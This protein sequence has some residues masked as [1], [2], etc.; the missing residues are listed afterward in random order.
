PIPIAVTRR[1]NIQYKDWDGSGGLENITDLGLDY[2]LSTEWKAENLAPSLEVTGAYGGINPNTGGESFA[3]NTNLT[4]EQFD[5]LSA[6][7]GGELA[8]V[9]LQG[10][11]PLFQPGPDGETSGIYDVMEGVTVTFDAEDRNPDFYSYM[12]VNGDGN[13]DLV[14]YGVKQDNDGLSDGDRRYEIT[15]MGP[16]LQPL[17]L[18][19]IRHTD[20]NHAARVAQLSPYL[21]QWGAARPELGQHG[22]DPISLYNLATES[23]D[24][25][26]I[27]ELYQIDLGFAVDLDLMQG[28]LASEEVL[29]DAAWEGLEF[30]TQPGTTNRRDALVADL[31][32]FDIAGY[33][34]A[35]P[36]LRGEIAESLGLPE[37]LIGGTHLAHHYMVSGNAEGRSIDPAGIYLDVGT[38]PVR[39]QSRSAGNELWAGEELRAGEALFSENGQ[40]AAE[41]TLGGDLVIRDLTQDG[42]PE[43]WDTNNGGE[44]TDHGGIVMQADGNLVVYDNDGAEF[45]HIDAGFS[46]GTHNETTHGAF[47]LRLENDGRL[48][49]RDRTDNSVLWVAGQGQDEHGNDIDN[50]GHGFFVRAAPT[51]TDLPEPTESA[52]AN[53]NAILFTEE[54]ALTYLASDPALI[55]QWQTA[56]GDPVLWARNHFITT[57]QGGEVVLNSNLV[58]L[59]LAAPGNDDLVMAFRDDP[60]GALRHYVTTGV[61]EVSAEGAPRNLA[62]TE[63]DTPNAAYLHADD[64]L[65]SDLGALEYLAA[66][67]GLAAD[68]MASDQDP[69]TAA[70]NHFRDIGWHPG[71]GMNFDFDV[72]SY[73]SA[74]GNG[75]LM[76]AFANDPIGAVN[77]YLYTG[78]SEF[79]EGTR[80]DLDLS[81]GETANTAALYYEPIMET[82]AG[83]LAYLASNPGLAADVM[84]SD[85]DPI[86]AARN[87]FTS[88][89]WQES[90][91][92]L[93]DFSPA[94][95]ISAPGNDDLVIAFADDPEGA[96]LHFLETGR[97]EIADGTRPY[98]Q[99][100]GGVEEN[101][102]YA[103]Y[104][105][106]METEEGAYTYL[107]SNPG[108]ID[109]ANENG[110][111]DLVTFARDHFTTSGWSDGF[112]MDF[113]A[114]SYLSAP[115]NADLARAFG[116]DTAA[117]V[118]HFVTTGY[119]EVGSETSNRVV[120]RD[121]ND[122]P[123]DAYLF[124]DL[125]METDEG[126][127][128]YL[129]AN[130]GLH[131]D[132]VASGEDPVT[133]A[134]NHF[135]AVGWQPNYGM[136]F[137]PPPST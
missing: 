123:S 119:G 3:H 118:E 17:G 57:G 70:R 108:L 77:H 112:S 25:A 54:G 37:E 94:S 28:V 131:D 13:P 6:E 99:R 43:I 42:H 63:E 107:A 86:T 44:N 97:N 126:A 11:N 104:D 109:Y 85:A 29:D 128:A 33:A 23:G 52:N 110:I 89:G 125:I 14:R 27:E 50:N 12:D 10:D 121:P 82:D 129:D 111:E 19:T 55:E 84:A 60:V 46:S 34:D 120:S 135:A 58:D 132:V 53:R 56:G 127:L 90:H 32:L 75:D 71:H 15:L 91:G 41:F 117:G 98:G 30:E 65:E 21:M 116:R 101:P 66:N 95:Y 81:E 87:H 1:Q 45:H 100:E 103:A 76:I 122:L 74:P 51:V 26:G 130:P 137:A 134:R 124:R 64:I 105:E 114:D 61:G 47:V 88:V 79:A 80:A 36:T 38:T 69:V 20:L 35:N 62:L 48:V 136:N 5:R 68:I 102:T 8:P 22:N 4:P 72:E 9:T 24:L 49:I 115:E 113:D 96:T 67:P 40:F 2:E 18:P 106:I 83:A 31:G 73:L 16:D 7:L 93:F 39:P 59:Y 92:M 78:T 133:E